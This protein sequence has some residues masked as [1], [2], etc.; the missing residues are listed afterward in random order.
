MKL[1]FSSRVLVG[2]VIS[3]VAVIILGGGVNM[4]TRH[5]DTEAGIG[6]PSSDTDP[7]GKFETATFALG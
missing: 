6:L 5:D 1:D 4:S 3:A 7:S 2:A